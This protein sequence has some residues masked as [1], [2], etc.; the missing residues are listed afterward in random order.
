[1]TLSSSTNKI[2]GSGNGITTSWPFSFKVFDPGHL[3]VTYT[4]ASGDETTL[5]P[6]QYVVNLNADQDASPG[7]TVTYSPPIASGTKLT[8][9]RSVP[10]TQAMDIKNQGGFFPEVL[11]RAIDLVVMQVQQVKEQLARAFKLSPSQSAIGELE[12]TDANRANTYIGFDAS[13]A[14]ALY[15]GVASGTA[16]SVAMAPVVSAASLSA[17]R[18]AMGVGTADIVN[19]QLADVPTATFKGRASAGTGAPEDLTQAQ[20]LSLLGAFIGPGHRLS[21]TTTLAVT[22]ADVVAA[23][24]VYWTPWKNNLTPIH[25]GAAWGLAAVAERSF[26]LDATNFLTNT[27]YDVF[28]DHNAGTPRIVCGPAWSSDTARSAAISRDA[29]YGWWVNNASITCRIS[30]NGGTV[31]KGAGTLHYLGTFRCTANGQTEDSAAKRF[32][33]NMYNRVLRRLMVR[34]TTNSWNHNTNSVWRQTRNSTTNQ[35]E[36]LRGLDEDLVRAE[37]MQTCV[38]GTAGDY[39]VVSLGLDSVT[40]PH[41]DAGTSINQSDLHTNSWTATLTI[42]PGIGRHYIAGLDYNVV[43]SHLFWYGDNGGPFAYH[44]LSAEVMA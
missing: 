18:D 29:T 25:N 17:A 6:G 40:V 24:T 28:L 27:N 22:V 42:L 10:Y 8:L 16:V 37:N 12:A 19:A 20:A 36:F 39:A 41:V 7:G 35:L 31:L 44:K 13:G 23:G 14:L 2:I 33:W 4:D 34:D 38:M 1:M 21:L 32:V 26:V 9:V 5:D 3:V 30:N 43:S 11:E 15:T